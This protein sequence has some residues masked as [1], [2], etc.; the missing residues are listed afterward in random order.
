MNEKDSSVIKA[1]SEFIL[2]GWLGEKADTFFYKLFVWRWK[3]KFKHLDAGTFDINFRSRRNVSKHHPQGFQIK[4]LSEYE[5][6]IKK[7]ETEFNLTLL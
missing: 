5:Q 6:R 3:N 7:F 2:K 4:V 1:L